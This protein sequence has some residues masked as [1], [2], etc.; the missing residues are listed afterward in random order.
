MQNALHILQINV[1]DHLYRPVIP[2]PPRYLYGIK[3]VIKN[4]KIGI[5]QKIRLANTN[6]ALLVKTVNI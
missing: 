3:N 1:V 4:E 5:T 6:L 2:S